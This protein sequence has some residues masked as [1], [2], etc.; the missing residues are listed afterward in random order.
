MLIHE[1]IYCLRGN[2]SKL[3]VSKYMPLYRNQ[4]NDEKPI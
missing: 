2:R 4:I 1:K 3:Y